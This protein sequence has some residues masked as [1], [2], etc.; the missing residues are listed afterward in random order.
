MGI[1]G[2]TQIINKCRANNITTPIIAIGGIT[3]N[4]VSTLLNSGV[5]G[6]AIASAIT[7]SK[8]KRETIKEFLSQL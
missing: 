5:Y 4:D 7:F 3:S 6:I 2:Y 8:D 1:E